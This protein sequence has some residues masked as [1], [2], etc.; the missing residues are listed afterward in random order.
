LR[1]GMGWYHF[2]VFYV[3]IYFLKLKNSDYAKQRKRA[4][5]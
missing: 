4:E 1:F 5:R 3:R 2:W